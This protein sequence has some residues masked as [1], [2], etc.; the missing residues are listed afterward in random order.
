MP[1]LFEAIPSVGVF[2]GAA[3]V[4]NS[5]FFYETFHSHSSL[6]NVFLTGFDQHNPLPFDHG[7]ACADNSSG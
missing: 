3:D 7:D 5:G 6:A 2:P 4:P 1:D